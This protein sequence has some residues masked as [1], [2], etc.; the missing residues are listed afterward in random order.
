MK[1]DYWFTIEPYVYIN[2]LN[3]KALL[4]N[5][6]DG[7]YIKTFNLKIIQILEEILCEKNCGVALLPQYV[8]DDIEIKTF[9]NEL[10]SKFMGDIIEVSLSEGKPVQILPYLNYKDLHKYK[11]QF[12]SLE[13]LLQT[14]CEITIYLDDTV[15]VKALIEYLQSFS[16]NLTYNIIGDWKNIPNGNLL[17]DYLGQISYSNYIQCSYTYIPLL[18]SS[19]KKNFSYQVYVSFPV[20]HFLMNSSYAFLNHQEIPFQY[21]FQVTSLDDCNEVATLIEKYDIQKY[22][23]KPLYTKDNISFFKG[24][25]FLTEKDIL[26]TKVN[27]RTIFRRHIIN[28][29]DFGK[30]SIHSNG[31]IYANVLHRKL[32]NINTDSIYQIIKKEIEIGESWLRIRNQKPCCDCLY[33][34]ICPSPSDLDFVIG[35]LNLCTVYNK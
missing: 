13:N 33:Q 31:D 34:Y 30:L 29:N 16:L 12:S 22:Q 7:K 26:S 35:Q 18:E 11:H 17:I 9:I 23:L 32:G 19:L 2:I 28:E 5:T 20:D 27:M 3:K 21:I 10:R 14:L 4:Y 24:N 25:I 8:Y 15:N 1:V 6:L